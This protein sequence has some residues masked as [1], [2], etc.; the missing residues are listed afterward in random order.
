MGKRINKGERQNRHNNKT[1]RE[2]RKL[3]QCV[4]SKI[5]LNKFI[6]KIKIMNRLKMYME[7]IA[8]VSEIV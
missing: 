8:N 1:E 3:S 2:C 4:S 6:L 7:F 5:E